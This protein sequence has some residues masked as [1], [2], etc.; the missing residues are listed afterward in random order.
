[1]VVSYLGVPK[2]M[3]VFYWSKKQDQTMQ[4]SIAMNTHNVFIQDVIYEAKEILHPR[5]SIPLVHMSK[6]LLF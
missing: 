2:K 6:H 4:I 1:M 5:C 3:L